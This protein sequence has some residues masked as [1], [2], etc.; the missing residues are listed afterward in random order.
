MANT[1]NSPEIDKKKEESDSSNKSSYYSDIINFVFT[2]FILFIII[3][4]YYSSSG[5]LLY[6]CKLG[7]SNILPTDAHCFPYTDNKL[8][9]QPIQ[10]NI[11]T[12]FNDPPLSMKM[13]FP[14]NE[15][16]AANKLLDMFREY[17]N[18]A[19]SNFLANY[20]IS[21]MESVV[22]FNYSAFNTILNML[23]GLPEILIIL[24]G[25]IIVG[26]LSTIIF[27][28]DHI[29]LIYLWFAKMGWFFKTN[30][31]DSNTGKPKWTDVTFLSPFNYW[32][33]LSLVILFVFIFFFSFPLVSIIAA[34][35]MMWCMFSCITY[36]AEMNGTNITA[37]TIVQDIFKYYKIPIMGFFSFLVIVTAFSKL[38]TYPGIFSL[39]TLAL[40]YYGIISIDIFNPIYKEKLSLLVSYKQAK[41]TCSYTEPTK[42]KRGLFYNMIFGQSGGDIAKELKNI[43]KRVNNRK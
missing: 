28:L 12:T 8:D 7:Q 24:F 25:P 29:Y 36:T 14:Y 34:L 37:A 40:I 18:E 11:F 23:N 27:L 32:C 4:V 15:E 17:K 41:K 9:I 39:L 3:I 43:S 20:F 22:Q 21:I 13:K 1:S 33:A 35:L 5:L 31:N 16:N 30:A 42:E 10:T 2:V 6:A 26:I 38:G 19:K